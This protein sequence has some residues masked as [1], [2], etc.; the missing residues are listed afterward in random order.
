MPGQHDAAEPMFPQPPIHRCILPLASRRTSFHS[1][2]NPVQVQVPITTA[3]EKPA[4]DLILCGGQ[5]VVDAM[6]NTD[7][8]SPLEMANSILRWGHL[9]PTAP[10]TLTLHPGVEDDAFV[11]QSLPN[12]FIVGGQRKFAVREWKQTCIVTLP[13]FSETGLA[14]IYDKSMNF[15]PLNVKLLP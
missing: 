1:L 9:C 5:N 6:K 15:V 7:I 13:K 10:D 4:L 2:S 12:L 8:K 11:L 3:K 14:V